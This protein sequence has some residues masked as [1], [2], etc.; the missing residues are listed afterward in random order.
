MIFI[1]PGILGQDP[2]QAIKSLNFCY[3]ALKEIQESWLY[4]YEV[5]QTQENSFTSNSSMHA[6]I[7]LAFRLK[8]E[9]ATSVVRFLG[10]YD[11]RLHTIQFQ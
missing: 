6:F 8:C 3:R 9:S 7:G 11:H 10:S 2:N 5:L 1:C 4:Q